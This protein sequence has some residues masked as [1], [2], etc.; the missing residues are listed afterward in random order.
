MADSNTP[1]TRTDS[2]APRAGSRGRTT[3]RRET[4]SGVSAIAAAFW[5]KFLL[6]PAAV[7]AAVTAVAFIALLMV[8]SVWARER[9]IPAAGR[10]VTD[11]MLVRADFSR[12]D[13]TAT[14]KDREV[15]RQR[16]PRVYQASQ[17]VFQ[18][19]ESSLLNLPATVVDAQSVD[20]VAP[21]IRD[22]FGLTDSSLGALRSVAADPEA[23]RN[24]NASVREYIDLLK[25][26]PILSPEDIQNQRLSASE[27]MELR[28]WDTAKTRAHQDRALNVGGERVPEELARAAR[29]SGFAPGML[30]VV[31]NALLKPALRPTFAYDEGATNELRE[32][33]AAAVTPRT[34]VYRQGDV[35][36]RRGERLD[37]TRRALLLRERVAASQAE[38]FGTLSTRRIGLA[39][40]VGILAAGMVAYLAAF[41]RNVIDRRRR[42]IWLAA[43]IVLTT[44]VAC[45]GAAF[46]P[47]YTVLLASSPSV[48][49]AATLVIAFDR[50]V[51]MALASIQ[52]VLVALSLQLGPGLVLVSITGAATSVWWLA[53]IRNR[54]VV[55][56]AAL[57]TGVGMAVAALASG[58]ISKP[59]VTGVWRDISLEVSQ[60]A[61]GGLAV[62]FVVVLLPLIEI[63]FDVVTPMR[64]IELRDPKQP[65]LREMA[66]RAPGSYTHSMGVA[67]IAEAAADAIGANG[68]HVYAGALYHDIGKMNKPEYFVE[69]QSGGIN[70]HE[71]LSPAMSLLVIVGHVKEGMEL[72]R[73]HTLPRSI[74][75]YIESHHGT[76]LVEYFFERAKRQAGEADESEP[77]E[78]GYRYPGPKPQTRE[79]AILMLS[80]A[81]E[82]A[83]RTLAE[84]TPSRIE[85]LVNS[86]A[87]KRLMDGQFDECDLTLRELH[88]IEKSIVKSLNSIYHARIVYPGQ[89]DGV[90]KPK[91]TAAPTLATRGVT[92]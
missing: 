7:P 24:W 17:P 77:F 66:Q 63:A 91:T 90:K 55:L 82:G 41:C 83:A 70:P 15:A 92:A 37:E 69:N 8:I 6:E 56:W 78:F 45:L 50:R 53:N 46:N 12:V 32:A 88:E 61:V 86:I 20:A 22:R 39:L 40:S 75:H 84:P 85:S 38:G 57:W 9:Y 11:T 31:S 29:Q 64:L 60:A 5:K 52:A 33:A 59:I 13:E 71:K 1:R 81:V 54:T 36:V 25:R 30:A 58:L 28:Y 47:E 76:T 34:V 18:D 2:G 49:L 74:R 3:R 23:L 79:A 62:G 26:T 14:E 68:L 65:L 67:A 19:V 89:T 10:I 4:P 42:M 21:E 72:A 87:T 48:L 16:Q 43:T 80:D 51:A 73:E 35:L 44:G 27:N